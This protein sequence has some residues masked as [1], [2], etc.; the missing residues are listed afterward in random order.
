MK[1]SKQQLV[2]HLEEFFQ[3]EFE[4]EFQ[5]QKVDDQSFKRKFCQLF[6]SQMHVQTQLDFQITFFKY[7]SFL[8]PIA[9][10][11]LSNRK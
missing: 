3:K 4:D 10:L 9:Y 1:I 5:I 8:C 2:I 6:W 11:E 7:H